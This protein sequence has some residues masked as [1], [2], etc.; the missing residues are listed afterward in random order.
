MALTYGQWSARKTTTT[1]SSLMSP[2]LTLVSFPL[3]STAWIPEN[4]G[5]F[6]PMLIF[7]LNL[8]ARAGLATRARTARVRTVLRIAAT[9]PGVQNPGRVGRRSVPDEAILNPNA[10]RPSLGPSP[11]GWLP[12]AALAGPGHAQRNGR[13][14]RAGCSDFLGLAPSPPCRPRL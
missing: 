14:W 2:R 11:G 3:G 10:A 4:S 9:P 12:V 7:L 8:P 5:A 13:H 1:T 6:W